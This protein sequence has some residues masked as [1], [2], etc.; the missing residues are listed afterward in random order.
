[1]K[2]LAFAYFERATK[3]SNKMY[4]SFFSY[5]VGRQYPHR[6]FTPT[7]IVGG[8]VIAALVSFDNVIASGYELA[9]TSTNNPN[10]IIAHRRWYGGIN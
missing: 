9:A 6:W 1:L 3:N 10:E 7:V 4:E 5:P 8:I 2:G